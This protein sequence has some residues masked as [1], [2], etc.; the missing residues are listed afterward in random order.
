M[1]V[2]W[3]AVALF[4][5]SNESTFSAVVRCLGGLAIAVAITVCSRVAW[6]DDA[7]QPPAVGAPSGAPT[8]VNAPAAGG[9]ASGSKPSEAALPSCLDQ[10]LRDELGAQLKP[11]GVQKRTFRK[12][13][14]LVLVGHGGLFGGDLTSSSWLAGGSLGVFL[15]EDFGIQAEFDVTPMALDLDKPLDSFFGDNRFEPAT[16]Y[17]AL[18]NLLWS[19]IHAKLK[20]GD[21]ITHADIMVF[22][23]AGRLFHDSV[24]GLSYDAGFAIDLFVSRV[25]TLRFDARDLMAIEE[26]AGE[27][28]YTNNLIVTG[29]FAI[30]IPVGL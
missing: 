12:D 24:Q 4:D 27:T 16:A 5:S 3:F 17:L 25:V 26:V 20:I 13:G 28:R 14:K 1:I 22:A 15:T 8:T 11:R 7:T 9:S 19:P 6:A 21:S 29:G 18:G 30:W 10:S 2:A 23:G